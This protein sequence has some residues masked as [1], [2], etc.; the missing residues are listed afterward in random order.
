MNTQE[1]TLLPNLDAFI[2]KLNAATDVITSQ[3]V[4]K[5]PEVLDGVL[6]LIQAR[7]AFDLTLSI[8][9]IVTCSYVSVKLYRW[10]NSWA[11]EATGDPDDI[12]AMLAVCSFFAVVIQAFP[13]IFA[14]CTL[15]K[16]YNWVALFYPEGALALRALEAA[17]ITM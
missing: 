17:G 1:E 2:G 7:A 11:K 13:V 15:T 16:F 9:V 6:H 10:L 8:G 5:A 14:I 3:V 4:S 12:A